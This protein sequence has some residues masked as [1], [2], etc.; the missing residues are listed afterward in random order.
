MHPQ[1]QLFTLQIFLDFRTIL[2]PERPLIFL[3]IT[4]HQVI[5]PSPC[6][7][8]VLSSEP[9]NAAASTILILTVKTPKKK[10]EVFKFCSERGLIGVSIA[11]GEGK[12]VLLQLA[13]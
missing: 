13:F 6:D 2:F 7:V 9:C 12:C 11:R 5:W 10:P 8:L 4:I 3:V 1:L